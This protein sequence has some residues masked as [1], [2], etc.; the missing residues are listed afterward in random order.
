MQPVVPLFAHV[1]DTAESKSWL[2]TQVRV[3][4]AEGLV[5]TKLVAFR[6][7]DQADIV[8]LLEANRDT[9]DIDL[10]RREWQPY[11]ASEVDRT[12]WLETAIARIVPKRGSA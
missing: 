7:Q 3:A 1:L 2:D 12:A 6:E 5:L 9:F 11:A 8:A 10:T 4:T